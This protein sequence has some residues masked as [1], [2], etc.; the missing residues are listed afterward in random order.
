M[1]TENE[2]SKIL[3]KNKIPQSTKNKALRFSQYPSR[4]E[5]IK[6]DIPPILSYVGQSSVLNEVKKAGVIDFNKYQK[7]NINEV[8]GINKN[9]SGF[10]YS[11]K[12]N[13]VLKNFVDVEKYKKA[14]YNKK[15]NLLRKL[16]KNN[17]ESIEYQIVKI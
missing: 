6:T 15:K 17:S 14:E 9:P 2:E 16:W 5:T 13:L 1:E 10:D 11:P 3:K 8:L 7:R 4:K 12:Y